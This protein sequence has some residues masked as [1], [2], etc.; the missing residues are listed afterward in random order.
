MVEIGQSHGELLDVLTSKYTGGSQK[1]QGKPKTPAVIQAELAPKR[2]TAKISIHGDNQ[3]I[4]FLLG[5]IFHDLVSEWIKRTGK[6]DE[7]LKK[8]F[9]IMEQGMAASKNAAQSVRMDLSAFGGEFR[10]QG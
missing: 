8:A 4:C 5:V 1:M 2:E 10:D 3:D 9:Y 7:T 6:P